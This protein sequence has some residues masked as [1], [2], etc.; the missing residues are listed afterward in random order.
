MQYRPLGPANGLRLSIRL[1]IDTEPFP[2]LRPWRLRW[3]EPPKD[4]RLGPLIQAERSI[5]A[6][7]IADLGARGLHPHER[8]AEADVALTEAQALID[9]IPMM[10][11]AIGERVRGIGLLKSAGPDY[12]TSHSEPR[13]PGW[14][15]LSVPP[16]GPRRAL[17]VTEAVIHEAMHHH[18]SALEDATPLALP[19][20]RVFSPWKRERREVSGVVHGVY[21]FTCLLASFRQLQ[22]AAIDGAEERVAEIK[23]EIGAIDRAALRVGLTP[24]GDQLVTA[25]FC[26]AAD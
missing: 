24:T 20:Q 23:R 5:P 1:G 3:L 12:D 18:L 21:V 10:S 16:R 6:D 19:G 13:W 7:A 26:D 17:R 8:D 2:R 9:L 25:L 11:Q 14:I 22:C 15:F 4:K